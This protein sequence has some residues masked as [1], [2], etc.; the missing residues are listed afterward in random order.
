MAWG[1]SLFFALLPLM[2]YPTSGYG[3]VDSDGY[4]C[5]IP[6]THDQEWVR[7]SYYGPLLVIIVQALYLLGLV[8]KLTCW[9]WKD[10]LNTQRVRTAMRIIGEKCG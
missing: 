2:I 1:L 9:D 4:E 8:F 6:D 7:I 10:D 5:W 3:P